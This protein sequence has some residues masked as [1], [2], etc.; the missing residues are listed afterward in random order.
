MKV[1]KVDV[2]IV[3]GVKMNCGLVRDERECDSANEQKTK[4]R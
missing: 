2:D 1:M 3:N 4:Q